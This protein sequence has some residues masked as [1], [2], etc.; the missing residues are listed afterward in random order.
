LEEELNQP[1]KE[2]P[3][4]PIEVPRKVQFAEEAAENCEDRL[5]IIME[6]SC[7]WLTNKEESVWLNIKS[8]KSFKISMKLLGLE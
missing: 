7:K 4:K 1:L 6:P 5:S 2:E 3:Q 8:Y